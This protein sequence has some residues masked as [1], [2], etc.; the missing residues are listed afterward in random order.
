MKHISIPKKLLTRIRSLLTFGL[1]VAYLVNLLIQSQVIENIILSLMIIVILLSFTA[2]TGS[3]KVIGY[4]SFS[5]SIALLLYYHAPL[6]VWQQALQDNL[7]LV[8]MFIMVPLVGIPIRQGGYTKALQ[9]LFERYVNSN[10]RYYLLVSF[11]SAFVG[12][13]VSL[14]VVPLVYQVSRNSSRSSNHKLLSSAISRGFSTCLTWAPT[15]AAIALVVQL[16]GSDWPTFF[17]FA[18][19]CGVIVGAVGYVMTV[20]EGRKKPEEPHTL[21][22]PPLNG[23]LNLNKILELGVFA[24]TLII[25]IAFF[26]WVSGIST[27]VVVSVLALIYPILWMTMIRRLPAFFQEFKGDYFNYRLPAIKNEMIL[28]IGAGF[29]ANSINFSHLGNYVPQILSHLVGNNVLLLTIMMIGTTLFLAALGVHPIVSVT[30]LG[31]TIKAATYGVS[32]TYLALVL[33]ASWSMGTTISPSS[34]NVIAVSSIVGE[35]PLRVGVRWNGPYVI[36]ATLVLIIFLTS[37][38]LIGML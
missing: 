12:V 34:A 9:S 31:G 14:A 24:I 29:L 25:G 7:F 20:F 8:V 3:S 17:P 19:S 32:P 16:T 22:D 30:I 13:L 28:F 37:M 33:T 10:N 38:R 23:D 18:I 36:L 21:E 2:V 35:S 26:S 11:L 27:I 4:L 15:T 1:A 5:V 6:S